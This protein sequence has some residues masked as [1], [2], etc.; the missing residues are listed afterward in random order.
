LQRK[1]DPHCGLVT[2]NLVCEMQNSRQASVVDW[3]ADGFGTRFM[4][5]VKVSD[6]S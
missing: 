4:V 1:R 6:E 2:S 3:D 5:P